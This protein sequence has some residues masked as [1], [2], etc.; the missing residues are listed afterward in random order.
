MHFIQQYAC[1]F[2]FISLHVSS[3]FLSSP[4]FCLRLLPL[5]SLLN[6]SWFNYFGTPA[7]L[8]HYHYL[9]CSF[10]SSQSCFSSTFFSTL[11]NIP[12]LTVRSTETQTRHT[13]SASVPVKAEEQQ[14]RNGGGPRGNC[15]LSILVTFSF[16][17]RA[18]NHERNSFTPT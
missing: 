12:S 2:L 17:D 8:R 11:E 1:H 13:G 16:L 10:S 14:R 15:F 7:T 18:I 3:S 4:P 5:V 6:S 9:T